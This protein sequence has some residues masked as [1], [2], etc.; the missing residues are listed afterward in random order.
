MLVRRYDMHCH[1]DFFADTEKTVELVAESGNRFLSVTV[2]PE[3]YSRAARLFASSSQVRVGLGLHPW[4]IADGRCTVDDLVAFEALAKHAAFVGEVGLDFGKRCAGSES[5]QREAFGRVARA[6]VDGAAQ[7]I[8]IH[9]V[10]AE[11]EV[12]DVLQRTGCLDESSCILHWFSG[13]SEQLARASKAGC[14]FSVG[15]RMLASKR[16]REYV[17][18]IP[19]DKLLVETDAPSEP[20][21]SMEFQACEQLL[22]ET[23]VQLDEILGNDI[24]SQVERTSAE[25]FGSLTLD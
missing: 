2:T 22:S 12:L 6:C 14:Y 16:G 23:L 5:V 10:K 8:S 3:G 13:S 18:A 25:L 11:D 21:S 20:A 1:L 7:V 15:P 19:R 4:W 17:K 24:L 9:A